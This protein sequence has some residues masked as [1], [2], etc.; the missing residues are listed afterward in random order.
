MILLLLVLFNLLAPLK[1]WLF[2]DRFI[3]Y[4]ELLVKPTKYDQI[5]AGKS[6][7]VIGKDVS[8]YKRSSLAT[9][10][11]NWQLSSMQLNELGY[12][13]NLTEVYQNFEQNPPQVIIDKKNL[14]PKLFDVMPT[15]A[16]SY[17]KHDQFGDVYIRKK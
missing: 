2:I 16:L 10:Y 9:P 5:V 15:I 14:I 17:E 13:D 6:V 1:N 11:L 7:L 4:S 3:S 8:C 12:Y